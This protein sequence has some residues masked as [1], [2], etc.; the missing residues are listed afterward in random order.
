MARNHD[1]EPE[2]HPHVLTREG[3]N[4]TLFWAHHSVWS[5][6]YPDA[7]YTEDEDE[8][9]AMQKKKGGAVVRDY[10][11]NSEEVISPEI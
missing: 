11:L 10:G 7:W 3:V 4:G 8:A 6:E 1:D 2:S 5:P 9:I